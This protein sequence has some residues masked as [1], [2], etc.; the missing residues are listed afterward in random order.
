MKNY[1][2]FMSLLF[3]SYEVLAASSVSSENSKE[4][5][6]FSEALENIPISNVSAM[7]LVGGE[8]S[9]I[10]KIQSSKDIIAAFKPYVSGNVK[11]AFA[12]AITPG[13]T[14]WFGVKPEAYRDDLFTRII[15]NLTISYAENNVEISKTKYKKSAY[16]ISTMFYLRGEDD[17]I[18]IAYTKFGGCTSAEEVVKALAIN[19][20]GVNADTVEKLEKEGQKNVNTAIKACLKSNAGSTAKRSWNSTKFGFSYGVG[21]IVSDDGTI[22]ASLG[23]TLVLNATTNLKND[24]EINFALRHTRDEVDTKTLSTTLDRKNYRL[25]ALRITSSHDTE[26]NLFWL[27]EISHSNTSTSAATNNVFKHA[28]GL[29]YRLT[30]D[31]WLEFRYGKARTSDGKSTENKGMMTFNFAPTSTLL[32]G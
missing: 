3:T 14:R 27:A 9:A 8:E 18:N 13:R 1:I 20:T 16:S 21:K 4:V 31:G 2:L 23:K 25:A 10:Q 7:S 24:V 15:G 17:P 5:F 11:N 32:G 28:I 30:K 12:V 19:T 26:R 22:N 29:D 6:L